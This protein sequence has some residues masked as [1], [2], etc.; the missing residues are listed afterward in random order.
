MRKPSPSDVIGGAVTA[1]A[2]GTVAT[3]L[4]GHHVSVLI[5]L[6]VVGT[7]ISSGLTLAERIAKAGTTEVYRCSVHDCSVEIRATKNHSAEKLASLRDM[8]TDH[9]RHT[10]AGA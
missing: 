3:H 7:M 9:S 2:T 10:T 8:A 1:V 6:A 5:L 4:I